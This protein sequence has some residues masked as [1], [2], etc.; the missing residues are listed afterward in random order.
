MI[1]CLLH[2]FPR[3]SL[4][5]RASTNTV[6][7]WRH[8]DPRIKVTDLQAVLQA[9]WETFLTNYIHLE[10][11]L[12]SLWK[13]ICPVKYLLSASNAGKGLYRYSSTS[14]TSST[15]W[16]VLLSDPMVWTRPV[17]IGWVPFKPNFWIMQSVNQS[18]KQK[19]ILVFLLNEPFLGI[20]MAMHK[21]K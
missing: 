5:Q 20:N 6:D 8:S 12:H 1:I 4:M 16:Y 10:N 21:H 14:F 2:Y 17:V 13:H 18:I 11:K 7:R 3:C 9:W 19:Y 15:S